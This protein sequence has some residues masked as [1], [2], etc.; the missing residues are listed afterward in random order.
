VG[1][2]ALLLAARGYCIPAIVQWLLEYG[3][4]DITDTDNEGTSV[5]SVLGLPDILKCTY[6]K[7]DDGEYV[8]IDGE[9]V[10]NGGNNEMETQL[11]RPQ[12]CASWCCTVGPHHRSPKI[13]RRRSSGSCKTA[14]GCGHDSQHI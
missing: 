12:C 3:G 14:R 1:K 4:A 9:Y 5:W 7:E 8:T 6:E 13:W 10:P 2:T 11:R